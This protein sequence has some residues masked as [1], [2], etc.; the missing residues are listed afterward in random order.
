MRRWLLP[1]VWA[2]FIYLGSSV[3]GK[4]IPG[5]V[6]QTSIILHIVEYAVLSM[7]SI[8]A[9]VAENDQSQSRREHCLW[10]FV[11]TVVYAV[12]DELHQAFVPGREAHVGDLVADAVGAG[13][14]MAIYWWRRMSVV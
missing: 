8:H 9:L 2:I 5:V 14:G 1:V 7:L 3:P 6:S 12:A 11:L 13:V 4:E 10:V